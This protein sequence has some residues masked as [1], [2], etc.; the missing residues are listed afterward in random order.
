M[1][2]EFGP[3]I[4]ISDGP[5][6][7]AAAGFHYPTRM[8]VMRLTGGDLM[9]WSPVAYSNDLH[10][11]VESL[12]QIRYLV[13]PNSL[14]DSFLGDWRHAC[15]QAFVFVA[16][17]LRETWSERSVT[18]ELGKNPIPEWAEDLDIVLVPGNRITT[19]AVLFHRAS[20]TAIFTD[21]LQQFPRGWFK[22]WR[23]LIARLDLMTAPEPTVPRKFRM[24]F[25]DR[26]AA[27]QALQA[28]LAWPTENVLIAHG[29]PVTGNGKAFLK[30]AFSWLIR[31]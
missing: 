11:A 3:N 30:R 7:T 23:A 28:I 31:D 5:I 16:P 26:V 13:A 17:G 8:T 22:G 1:L 15:P 29:P 2:E 27:R 6:V 19:E 21:L 9:L 24:A 12:G 14:H 20:R 10:S 18:G 25:T 4:W